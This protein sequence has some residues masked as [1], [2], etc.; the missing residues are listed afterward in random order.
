MFL[1][2]SVQPQV[3]AFCLVSFFVSWIMQQVVNN[4]N[5]IFSEHALGIKFDLEPQ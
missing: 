1:K 2:W 5:E 3:T 4:F